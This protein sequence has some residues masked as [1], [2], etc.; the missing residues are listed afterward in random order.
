[1]TMTLATEKSQFE[2]V[3]EPAWRRG[4]GTLIKGELMSMIKKPKWWLQVLW[5][6]LM[7]NGIMAII[8]ME[9]GAQEGMLVFFIFSGIWPAFSIIAIT[10]GEI[11]SEVKSGTAAW[12]LSKPVARN[13]FI[14]SKYIANFIASTI[15]LFVLPSLVAY[16]QLISTPDVDISLGNFVLAMVVVWFH[17]MVYLSLCLM[18]GTFLKNQRAVMALGITFLMVQNML[19]GLVPDQYLIT[20]LVFPGNEISVGL[21]IL[22]IIIALGMIIGSYLIALWQ[23]NRKEF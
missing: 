3:K 5:M 13:S 4:F 23:F 15:F 11:I 16:I 7:I 2:P 10:Q 17:G 12:V 18:L 14:T 9:E 20:S 8:L 22:P 19:M 21:A 6:L 1:M